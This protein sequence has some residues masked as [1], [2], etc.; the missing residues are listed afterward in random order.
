MRRL[1]STKNL[2]ICWL[3]LSKRN[4]RSSVRVLHRIVSVLVAFILCGA[5]MSTKSYGDSPTK[6]RVALA[7]YAFQKLRAMPII[8]NRSI[9]VGDVVSIETESVLRSAEVCYPSLSEKEI[10]SGQD[11]IEVS[12][13]T[14]LQAAGIAGMRQYSVFRA[15]LQ[16]AL[17]GRSVLLIDNLKGYAPDPD[18]YELEHHNVSSAIP[19][20]LVHTIRDGNSATNILVS[21]VY[22]ADIS[23]RVY[24][25]NSEFREVSVSTSPWRWL[26]GLAQV[27]L[28]S[29][30]NLTVIHLT[31]RNWG[32]VAVQALRLNLEELA[33]LYTL[34]GENPQT[35]AEY[36]RHVHRYLVAEELGISEEIRLFFSNIFEELGLSDSIG[37]IKRR[38]VEG[39]T[40]V[41]AEQIEEVPQEWWDAVGVVAAGAE[42]IGSDVEPPQ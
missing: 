33:R 39:G 5:A 34:F 38:L 11:K 24:F 21:S 10:F 7:M 17:S 15:D 26:L 3:S 41:T 4:Q 25:R 36:E 1:L 23:G 42:I 12:H 2:D 31:G 30:D 8:N 14:A 40:V 28:R 29:E 27:E 19:C 6:Y 22:R 18:Q 13:D 20:Q 37:D 35:I 9:A 16:Q 32:S